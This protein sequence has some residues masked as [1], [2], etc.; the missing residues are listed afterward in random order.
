MEAFTVIGIAV[1]VTVLVVGFLTI[2]ERLLD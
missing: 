2:L 1:V